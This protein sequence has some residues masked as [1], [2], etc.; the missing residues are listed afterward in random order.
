MKQLHA[1]EEM[2]ISF[3]EDRNFTRLTLVWLLSL[4]VNREQNLGVRTGEKENVYL[5]AHALPAYQ[6]RCQERADIC[7]GSSSCHTLTST[8][9]P[10]AGGRPT[11]RSKDV[12]NASGRRNKATEQ[13][14]LRKWVWLFSC[15][16]LRKE[17][18][19]TLLMKW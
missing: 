3:P 16:L 2:L 19:I 5:S 6:R 14:E 9:G 13:A 15:F 12:G 10:E 7:K 4:K 1:Q 17:R 18:N 8:H 11:L